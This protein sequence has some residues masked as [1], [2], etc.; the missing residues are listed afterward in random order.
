MIF[1][2]TGC[3]L[4]KAKID[5][6]N[7]DDDWITTWDNIITSSYDDIEYMEDVFYDFCLFD[8]NILSIESVEVVNIEYKDIETYF[9]KD[10]IYTKLGLNL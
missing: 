9:D 7:D 6:N 3:D 1:S 5:N 2:L 8:S 4:F 10:K